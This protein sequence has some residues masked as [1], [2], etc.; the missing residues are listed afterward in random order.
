MSNP[1]V[2]RA[3]MLGSVVAVLVEEGS[4]VSAG[5]TLLVIEVMKVHSNIKASVSGQV[6]KILIAAT[7]NVE[8]GA[9]L[10]E[11]LAWEFY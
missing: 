3:P 1:I 7:D 5:D 9:P 6:S 11:L 4:L 8:K 10:V 2:V